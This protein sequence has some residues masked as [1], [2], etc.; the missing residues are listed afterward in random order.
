M[1]VASGSRSNDG[2]ALKTPAWDKQQAAFAL[3]VPNGHWDAVESAYALLAAVRAAPSRE[4]LDSDTRSQFL[5]AVQE[6]SA[7]L[8]EATARGGPLHRRGSPLE[9]RRHLWGTRDYLGR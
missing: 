8:K 1:V 6:A 9:R 5:N 7:L 2:E 3:V 4:P